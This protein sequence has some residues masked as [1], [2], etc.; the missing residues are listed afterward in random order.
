MKRLTDFLDY[1]KKKR[2][3]KNFETNPKNYDRGIL[4]A[5][6]EYCNASVDIILYKN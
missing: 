3:V 6:T 2:F 1:L 4:L 5:T